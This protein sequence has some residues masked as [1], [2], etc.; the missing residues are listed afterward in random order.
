MNRFTNPDFSFM[1]IKVL[2]DHH[3]KCPVKIRCLHHQEI[4]GLTNAAFSFMSI[5]ASMLLTRIAQASVIY[6]SRL[7]KCFGCFWLK[8]LIFSSLSLIKV[9]Q[10]FSFSPQWLNHVS[11]SST[12]YFNLSFLKMSYLTMFVLVCSKWLL[13]EDCPQLC[14]P[15]WLNSSGTGH[16]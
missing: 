3:F 14:T 1:L 12:F 9:F 10:C 4:T 8:L 7:I 11:L 15:K 16:W 13:P 5:S 6:F 2:F